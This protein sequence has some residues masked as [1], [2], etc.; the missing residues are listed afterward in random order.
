M[1][2]TKKGFLDLK[3]GDVAIA[4]DEYAHDYTE[5]RVRLVSYEYDKECATPENPKGLVFFGDDL[6]KDEWGDDY[7]TRVDIG[8]YAGFVEAK[9][10]PKMERM[11]YFDKNGKEVLPGMKIR[12]EDGEIETV[13]RTV[14]QFGYEDLG[15]NAS[16]EAYLVLHP[17]ADREYYSLSNW[18]ADSIEIVEG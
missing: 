1:T 16:N 9:D 3:Q 2:R 5:H 17:T 10:E 13:H 18:R 4:T 6:D 15:V 12:F 8:N 11:R 7:I 14:S